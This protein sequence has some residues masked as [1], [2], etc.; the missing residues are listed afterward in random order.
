[1]WHM[2]IANSIQVSFRDVKVEGQTGTAHWE[3]DYQFRK[4]AG[5]EPRPVHNSVDA[6]FRFEGGLIREHRD[7]CDFWKWFEQAIGPTGKGAH[8]VDVLEDKVEQLLKRDL[9]LNVEERVRAKVRETARQKI[10]AF[11]RKHP[12]YAG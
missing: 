12:E 1:M 7:E 10:D 6:R 4:E 9:P 5:S 11:I 2:I 3:C 8:M